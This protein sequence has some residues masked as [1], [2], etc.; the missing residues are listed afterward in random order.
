MEA[1]KFTKCA[2]SNVTLFKFIKPRDTFVGCALQ[3]DARD[4]C[5]SSIASINVSSVLE[6][7]RERSKLVAC[8]RARCNGTVLR[9]EQADS[10]FCSFFEVEAEP[11]DEARTLNT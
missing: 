6:M 1:A 11:A 4:A 2:F 9:S 3:R 5:W 8:F 7:A 10:T